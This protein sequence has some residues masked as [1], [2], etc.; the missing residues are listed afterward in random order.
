MSTCLPNYTASH[1]A[2]PLP[3]SKVTIYENVLVPTFTHCE[4]AGLGFQL[5]PVLNSYNLLL[6]YRRHGMAHVHSFE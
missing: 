5:G 3:L 2:K 6:R 4:F 1:T